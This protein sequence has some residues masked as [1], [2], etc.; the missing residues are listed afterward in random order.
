MIELETGDDV[1]LALVT[2]A[3]SGIGRGIAREL[4]KKGYDLI[5]V[6]RTKENLDE[7][8]KELQ[9]VRVTVLPMDLSKEENCRALYESVKHKNI[10]LLVNDAGFGVFG[11]FY[12]T[13]LDR[14]LDMIR[15]NDIAYHILTKLFLADF[16][17][18]DH[19]QILNV[20]SSAAFYTGPKMA[21]YYATKNYA[22]CMTASIY[23][24]LRKMKS[25]VK[26][27]ALCPGP[28]DTN[29]NNVAGVQ[30]NTKPLTSEYVA[31]CAIKGLEKNKLLIIPG[32]KMKL[33][34]FFC[35][36]L[37]EKQILRI[38]YKQQSKKE[39]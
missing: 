10:D 13:D 38:A 39:V 5:I 30:F 21:G 34:K 23:E 22:Y 2:G 31:K 7:V 35:R 33:A 27:S 11:E 15:V 8:K 29:F 16:V 18:R 20:C 26:I 4:A 37:S 17:K 6:S 1:M 9:D 12:S 36:F 14:E 3:S 25:N 19:G 32:I 24:E 28:V